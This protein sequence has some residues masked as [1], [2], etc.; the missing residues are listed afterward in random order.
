MEPLDPRIDATALAGVTLVRFSHQ[1][2]SRGAAHRWGRRFRPM[3]HSFPTTE[4]LHK[5]WGRPPGLRPTPRRPAG[6][7]MTLI[8]LSRLRDEGV[9][10]GPG[11]PPSNLRPN[12]A[13]AKTK[14]H[15]EQPD[16]LLLPPG[17]GSSDVDRWPAVSAWQGA[18]N[19]RG[20]DRISGSTG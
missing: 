8:S 18:A 6:V 4:H 16:G 15:S 13:V 9:P 2:S 1:V 11:G 10:R 7:C 12:P 17:S 5:L 3:P 14:W 19:R 20:W